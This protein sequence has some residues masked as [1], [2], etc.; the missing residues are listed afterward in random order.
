MSLQELCLLPSEIVQ[1]KINT[2]KHPGSDFL[3]RYRHVLPNNGAQSKTG[4]VRRFRHRTNARVAHT[5][6]DAAAAAH[7][8]WG[9]PPAP[10]PPA[11]TAAQLLDK[12]ARDEP[13]HETRRAVETRGLLPA[14]QQTST[15]RQEERTPNPVRSSTVDAYAR[16]AAH[17]VPAAPPHDRR[18]GGPRLTR[19][20]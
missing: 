10:R 2:F 18:H 11:R 16:S 12:T 14:S 17:T 13:R 15:N 3:F 4:F 5:H 6:R 1:I 8:G 20:V 9:L 19:T 7:L